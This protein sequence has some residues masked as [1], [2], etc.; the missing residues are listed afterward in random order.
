M[1]DRLMSKHNKHKHGKDSSDR[2][3]NIRINDTPS[4]E[5]A[6]DKVQHQ[7][8]A[9]SELEAI[10]SMQEQ[11]DTDT[12]ADQVD[13]QTD[14]NVTEQ[15]I[16]LTSIEEMTRQRDEL[17]ERL[18]R[19]SA[20]YQNYVKRAQAN[21]LVNL[22]QQLMEIARELVTVLD[23]FD[24]ALEVNPQ[25]TPTQSLLDGVVI[26]RDELIRTLQRYGL[27]KI[28]VT[29]GDEFDPTRHE[30]LIHQQA[31]GIQSN[32]IASQLQPGYTIKGKTIRPA[33]VSVAQ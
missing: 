28:E 12:Q 18:L 22:D 27:E 17:H 14:T 19:V 31:E 24:H 21:L 13:E 9:D 4:P 33:K 11:I 20:D 26:V 15:E 32:H 30:A 16:N 2:K 6:G 8:T 7:T 10:A 1:K 25:N 3:V 5:K 29:P 23:H